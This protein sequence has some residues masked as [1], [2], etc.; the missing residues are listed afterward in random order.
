M[1]EKY[2]DQVLEETPARAAKLLNGIGAVPV[3]RT[4]MEQGGMTDDDIVEGGK[5]LVAS[6]WQLPGAAAE[7]DTDEARQQRAATAELDQWDEPNFARY[8]AALRRRFPGAHDYVFH[9]LAAS[10]G[11]AA[12]AGV[13][14]FLKRLEVLE[15]GTD[16]ARQETKKDDKKAAEL[17]SSRGLTKDERARLGKLVEVALR[18]TTTL[19]PT[20]DH[21]IE[22]RA[23]RKAALTELKD[24][25]E[26]W[27]TVARAVVKKRA[28]LI[29]MGLA[30]RKVGKKDEG[31]GAPS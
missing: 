14:T 26:E 27:A 31:E 10:T 6:W 9:D 8:G 19:A 2:S 18:P 25:Y 3:I 13:A 1:A 30:S 29:R 15:K 28:Y 24:W 23:A 17:V 21:D 7:R 4:L 12:V 5:L 22:R 11:A 16:P 20:A